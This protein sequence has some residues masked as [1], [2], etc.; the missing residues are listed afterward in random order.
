MFGLPNDK[1]LYT[2]SAWMGKSNFLSILVL[3]WQLSLNTF[4]EFFMK[5][6][7]LVL[8]QV[9]N[10]KILDCLLLVCL[11][12]PSVLLVCLLVL[13]I[14]LVLGTNFSF[15]MFILS[16]FEKLQSSISRK[17]MKKLL[18]FMKFKMI[19]SF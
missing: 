15:S 9:L 5:E 6:V 10:K 16:T 3:F 11:L 13:S 17:K 7:I 4:R 2:R 8:N 12:V 1:I 14:L 19:I 18:F